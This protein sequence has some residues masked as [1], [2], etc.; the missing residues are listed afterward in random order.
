[1]ALIEQDDVAR[2]FRGLVAALA[3]RD[4]HRLTTG[5]QVAEIYQQLVPYRTHRGPLGFATHQ[6]YEAAI[7]GLL[8]GVGGFASLEP[9]EA[10][11]TLASEAA[12]PNPDPTLFREFAGARVR[13]S[14]DRVAALVAGDRAYAPAAVEPPKPPE[15]P[16]VP[17]L[18]ARGPVFELAPEVPPAPAPA[19]AIAASPRAGHCPACDERLPDDR[20]VVFCPFC[21]HAVGTLCC[22]RCG[23]ELEPDW[24]FCPRC[25]HG[26]QRT[27]RAQP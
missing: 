3:Q 22:A 8:A 5:F 21:G 6:D 1:V 26:R 14:P 11:E 13:L 12:S 7:L 20:P 10:Q 16:A 9:T 17:V 23:D 4:A 27:G 25:G 15:T 19:P 18:T 2:L 24:R